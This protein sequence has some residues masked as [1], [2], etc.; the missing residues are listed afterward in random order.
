LPL[1]TL[2]D[3]CEIWGILEEDKSR[4]TSAEINFGRR[5]ANAHGKITKPMKVFY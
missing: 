1:P 3:G 5:S 2:I 4:I